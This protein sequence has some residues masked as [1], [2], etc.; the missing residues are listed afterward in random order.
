M[1]NKKI[2][3]LMILGVLAVS[4][5]SAGWFSDLFQGVPK[6]S[7]EGDVLFSPSNFGLD[8]L[9]DGVQLKRGWNYWYT[10]SDEDLS[11][12]DATADLEG[13]RYIL[14][15]DS[16]WKHQG[17]WYPNKDK[18]R[19]D[20]FKS[21]Y[22]YALY[23]NK[24]REWKY[25]PVTCEDS[26]GGLNYEEKGTFYGVERRDDGSLVFQEDGSPDYMEESDRCQAGLLLEYYCKDDKGV[27]VE[28]Y[29]C[30]SEGKVCSDGACVEDDGSERVALEKSSNK[31]NL[32]E[33]IRDVI[34]FVD[35]D[36][37]PNILKDGTY[38]DNQGNN[39]DYRQKVDLG[40]L[41]LETFADSDYNNKEE[42]T[43]IHL[44]ANDW[45]MD[46]SLDFT[47]TVN[48][49]NLEGTKIYLLGKTFEI[50][51]VDTNNKKLS[52]SSSDGDT[53]IFESGKEVL[54]N[55]DYVDNFEVIISGV[56]GKITK[57]VIKWKSD[58]EAFIT[59]DRELKMPVFDNLR[60]KLLEVIE[61]DVD[62]GTYGKLWLIGTY[63]E[64]TSK[65]VDSEDSE[66]SE[67]T[68]QG[69]LEMMGNC[70]GRPMLTASEQGSGSLGDGDSYSTV[71]EFCSEISPAKT[72]IPI[73]VYDIRTTSSAG[74]AY[75]MWSPSKIDSQIAYY[76]SSDAFAEMLYDNYANILGDDDFNINLMAICC[77]AP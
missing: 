10:W 12:K 20:E 11:I 66:S 42:T 47:Q 32:G 30:S 75:R 6:P 14:T 46:Y 18:N 54:F 72:R 19:Y 73:G 29:D 45:I 49:N 8:D 35:D 63:F 2:L 40:D 41:V 43:G 34:I 26:D 3:S 17:Y 44:R 16:N 15:Y 48:W 52:L 61:N 33:T 69:V 36:N 24:K 68:Y 64:D 5:V 71:A 70:I 55:G 53:L 57:I 62:D 7:D 31:F 50:K 21:G 77:S 65:V 25:I 51:T 27:G 28:D 76:G 39:F 4:L 9:A 58:D 74:D 56:S 60:F 13:L 37:L 59:E 1:N 22:R 38:V 23:M 67:V